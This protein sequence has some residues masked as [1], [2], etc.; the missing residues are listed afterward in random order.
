[1]PSSIALGYQIV[2]KQ[3]EVVSDS[4]DGT[5]PEVKITFQTPAFIQNSKNF[6]QEAQETRLIF[7]EPPL[8][9]A[10]HEGN[11]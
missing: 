11:K 10:E 2:P 5:L 4:L 6:I 1:M 3:S 8:C 7:H 9:P